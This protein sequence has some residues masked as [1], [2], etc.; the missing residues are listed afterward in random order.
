VERLKELRAGAL[1]QAEV[2]HL[3]KELLKA[4]Q[5]ARCYAR[6]ARHAALKEYRKR[7]FQTISKDDIKAQLDPCTAST[8]NIH[9]LPENDPEQTSILGHE[10]MAVVQAFYGKAVSD[11]RKS[12]ISAIKATA[13]LCLLHEKGNANDTRPVKTREEKLK[14]EAMLDRESHSN[15][16]RITQAQFCPWGECD[17]FLLFEEGS[18]PSRCNRPLHYTISECVRHLQRHTLRTTKCRFEGC[19]K[20]FP[21]RTHLHDHASKVHMIRMTSDPF[22][23]KLCGLCTK[24]YTIES[25]WIDHCDSHRDSLPMNI[26]PKACEGTHSGTPGV[27]PFCVKKGTTGEIRFWWRL[28]TFRTHIM[29]HLLSVNRAK[30]FECPHSMCSTEPKSLPSLISH[31][32]EHGISLTSNEQAQVLAKGKGVV[33]TGSI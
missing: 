10:R 13:S 2:Q 11:K 32:L 8:F 1:D 26:G 20:S 31:L 18:A 27:C 30:R 7:W 33:T 29:V 15:L 24:Y 14:L 17:A 9:E 28:K 6:R 19:R 23:A 12:L 22:P 5:V 25:L 21:S 4:Q 16:K 3:S